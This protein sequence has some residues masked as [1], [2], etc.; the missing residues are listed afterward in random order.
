MPHGSFENLK[1]HFFGTYCGAYLAYLAARAC[2]GGTMVL[3]GGRGHGWLPWKA[4]VRRASRNEATAVTG[5]AKA[6]VTHL[7]W[8]Q[9]PPRLRQG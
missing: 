9:A 3:A 4:A 6:A 1:K 2:S 5:E 8:S 7:P